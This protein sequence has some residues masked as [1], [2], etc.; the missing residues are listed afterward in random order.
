MSQNGRPA[1]HLSAPHEQ[2]YYMKSLCGILDI[3]IHS[4][5]QMNTYTN[6]NPSAAT[7]FSP[8]QSVKDT[9]INM[10]ENIQL[11]CQHIF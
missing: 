3:P 4:G 7:F 11:Q 2:L 5:A 6:K 8:S 10:K 9:S 1:Q